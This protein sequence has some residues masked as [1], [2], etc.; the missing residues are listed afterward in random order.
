MRSKSNH[1]ILFVVAFSFLRTCIPFFFSQWGSFFVASEELRSKILLENELNI[2]I[3]CLAGALFLFHLSQQQGRFRLSNYW[4]N[5]V[6]KLNRKNIFLL[7]RDFATSFRRNFFLFSALI[8]IG[9]LSGTIDIEAPYSFW[10]PFLASL[11]YALPQLLVFC[12][13]LCLLEYTKSTIL[14]LNQARGQKQVQAL[15]VFSLGFEF[16]LVFCFLLSIL[17]QFSVLL[18]TLMAGTWVMSNFLVNFMRGQSLDETH[19]AIQ[20][21]VSLLIAVYLSFYFFGFEFFGWRAVSFLQSFVHPEYLWSVT[22]SVYLVILLG[23]FSLET[24][25]SLFRR[26]KTIS[27]H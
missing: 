11:L 21:V 27:S 25:M 17:S 15:M 3:I 2:Q 8:F 12:V 18:L 24:L 14:N 5:L 9:I 10:A 7:S 6:S 20:R 16:Y 23:N 19:S 4:N 26:K 1:F 13:W 22:L